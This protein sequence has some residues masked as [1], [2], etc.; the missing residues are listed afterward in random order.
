MRIDGIP[1]QMKAPDQISCPGCGGSN[2]ASAVFCANADCRKA[3]GDFKY[4]LEEVR[5]DSDKITR[6]A[7]RVNELTG[8]P[9]FVTVHLAWFA[10]WILLN[11][12]LLTG[13]AVFDPEY[14]VTGHAKQLFFSSP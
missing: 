12:G 9:H 11:A 4:V 7:D 14:P 13:V 1:G 2:P 10:G 8:R 5:G 3:L 6:L